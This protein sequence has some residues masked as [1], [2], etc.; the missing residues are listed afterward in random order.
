MA[1]AAA[2]AEKRGPRVGDAASLWNFTPAPGWSREEVQILRLCLM[3]HGVGQWMQILSTGLLP[4]KLIQQLN[5]QTQRL[6]GQQSLAA[7]TGLKVDVDRIRVDNETRTDATRKAGLIIN[8]GPNLTKEMKEKMRQDAVAKYGLTP[9]QVAEVD[10]QLAEIAAAFN[11]ASTSAAAGAGSGAAAAGQAAAAGSGAG[12][13]GQ[14][15][16]A[17]DA[18]G[19]AGRGTGSAGGAAAAAPP[20]N[21]LAISTGVLAATLL[22]A[23][24]GNLMAQPTEQLS[25][26]QLGQL[27]LRLRN[28]LACLVDRA[29]GRAGLPPRTAPRWATEAAAAACLAAM[30][31]AEASAPQAPAAAAGG[32]EGA[33]GPV[34]VSVPFSREVLAE[35]TAC[36]VRS[37]TAA[38]A[39]GNAPGAQGGVRKRTSKGGKA[40][41]GD[42]EWSPEGEEN[43]AP[44]PR[45]GGKRKSGAVAGGEEADG[46]ASGRAKRASRPK[47][48]SSKHDPYVDDN[49]YGDEGIDPFDVGDDLDDM[50][51]HG[52]YGNGGG[53]R[54]DPSEAISAL[55]A[56]GFT[57]SK[58][59]GALRECNFNVELA[60]EWLFANCL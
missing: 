36:R 49:D 57:Q 56:M 11:P 42:R 10:E 37:G 55:T 59:R 21:A 17:A 27:L 9:E 31:A 50:N 38:G 25:A 16:T 45:G 1:F 20:R 5:G 3:K 34:M 18:G 52:R 35:A 51:P 13:S 58:A 30:A 41:G 48:G 22:D 39:R 32:Q 8:D 23:S 47:R 12:G 60:V 29:R 44:Q 53:R 2:L 28:R 19:A 40:K 24:L 33:A 43:T 15:A 7:Y 26:E 6:L 54:A 4:G 14:A 46:V